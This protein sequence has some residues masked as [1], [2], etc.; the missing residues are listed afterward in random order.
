MGTSGVLL[1]EPAAYNLESSGLVFLQFADLAP[2]S[3]IVFA[4][5]IIGCAFF[6]IDS[7]RFHIFGSTG[8]TGMYNH[9]ILSGKCCLNRME[10]S[11]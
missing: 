9:S 8:F 2:I 4:I 5:S 11:H 7:F 6:R 1:A 10:T 3:A